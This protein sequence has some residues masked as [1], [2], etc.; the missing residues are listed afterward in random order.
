M[1]AMSSLGIS[2]SELENMLANPDLLQDPPH[3][4]PEKLVQ[5]IVE[6]RTRWELESKLPAQK[7]PLTD[8]RALQLSYKAVEQEMMLPRPGVLM[9]QTLIG[10]DKS[11]ST[12]PVS[13]LQ[14]S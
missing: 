13:R 3:F 5:Q 6:A 10:Q 2:P 9:L 4:D 12:T 11:F 1:Q 7:F 8:R 14:M